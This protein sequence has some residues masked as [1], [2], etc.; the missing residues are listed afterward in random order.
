MPAQVAVR[1]VAVAK[2]QRVNVVMAIV[3]RAAII[4]EAADAAAR[5]AVR[6]N[7]QHEP[8][9]L[10]DGVDARGAVP[11][12]RVPHLHVAS[13][14]LGARGAELDLGGPFLSVLQSILYLP[15]ACTPRSA[16]FLAPANVAEWKG[17]G[18]EK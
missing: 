9:E 10:A 7:N 4:E 12:L 13:A 15:R 16:V 1:I 18:R 3:V 17:R 6:V 14:A 11:F 2:G 5:A 8:V